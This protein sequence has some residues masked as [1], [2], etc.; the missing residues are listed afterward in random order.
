MANK[1]DRAEHL[2]QIRQMVLHLEANPAIPLPYQWGVEGDGPGTLWA[3]LS[4]R[5]ALLVVEGFGSTNW[6]RFAY[7][8]VT[9]FDKEWEG[10]RVRV[11][12]Y[13]KRFDDEEDE[14]AAALRLISER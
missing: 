6:G 13:S 2:N 12:V 7:N 1:T 8:D 14:A 11:A 4:P 5:D 10:I 9:F 3:G